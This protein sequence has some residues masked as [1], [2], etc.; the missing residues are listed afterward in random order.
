[1]QDSPGIRPRLILAAL[2]AT[3]G[4]LAASGCDNSVTV[5]DRETGLYSVYGALDIDSDVN[6][7]RVKDLNTPLVAESTRTLDATVTLKNLSSG[8]SSVLQDSVVEFQDVYTHNFR[9]TMEIRPSTEYRV[10]VEHPDGRKT[11]AIGTTPPIADP[12][13]TP[14]DEDCLTPVTVN[15]GQVPESTSI[16][17]DVGVQFA[18]ER[19]WLPFCDGCSPKS[20]STFTF[21]FTPLEVLDGIFKQN[22]QYPNRHPVWCHNLDTDEMYVRY[23]HYGPDFYGDTPSD[24]LTVPGGLGR[25]GGYYD[26]SFSFEIDTTN[27]CAPNC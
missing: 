18:G 3:M 6:F 15:L 17:I 22:R 16:D 13:A 2:L 19:S 24:S 14:A 7:I 11:Q 21:S 8:A 9:S 12:D 26:A 5:L 10:T 23:E 25:F 27:L 4:F 1:M 20:G